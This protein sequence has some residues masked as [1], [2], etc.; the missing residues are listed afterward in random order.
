MVFFVFYVVLILTLF[1]L[2]LY[3]LYPLMPCFDNS[4]IS[5]MTTFDA[6]FVLQWYG[7]VYF[8]TAQVATCMLTIHDCIILKLD[9]MWFTCLINKTKH[10]VDLP[11]FKMAVRCTRCIFGFKTGVLG[12][13]FANN[14]VMHAIFLTNDLFMKELWDFNE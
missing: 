13:I 8:V 10:R 11:K 7:L 2:N 1:P 4:S 3:S 9:I 6:L 5:L 12:I 14:G